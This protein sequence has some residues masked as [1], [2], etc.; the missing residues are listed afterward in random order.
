M[1]KDDLYSS[2]ELKGEW[3]LPNNKEQRI[4]GNLNFNPNIGVR[5]ELSGDFKE[6]NILK[7]RKEDFDIILGI[8]SDNKKITLYRCSETSHSKNFGENRIIELTNYTVLYMFKGIHASCKEELMFNK[9]SARIFNLD[10]WLGIFGLSKYTMPSEENEYTID[11]NYKLP[12]KIKFEIDATTT[13]CFN[14]II[15]YPVMLGSFTKKIHLNQFAKLEFD[16]RKGLDIYE[17]IN[18]LSSFQSFLTFAL[19]ESTAIKSIEVY[20]DQYLDEYEPD[21]YAQVPIEVFYKPFSNGNVELKHRM[22]MLF[23]YKSIQKEFPSIIKKWYSNKELLGSC[24]D[25]VFEQFHNKRFSENT[26]LNLA[27][28]AETFHVRLYNHTKMPKDDYKKMKDEI[29]SATPPL[30]HKWLNEQFNFGNNLNLHNRL[31]ELVDKYS[32]SIIDKMI[33]DKDLFIKQI[34]DSRNYYTHYSKSLEKKALKGNELYYL[35][36]KL[37]ILLVCA[38]LIEIG[39]PKNNLIL[40]LDRVKHTYFHYLAE[41]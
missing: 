9:I 6:A 24:I 38:F 26:F 34:K 25:L 30:Y 21:K 27:Q 33:S 39:I 23:T 18:Y 20:S 19:Y 37:Q 13:G 32:N 1:N 7:G 28:A 16:F 35:T 40:S 12:T 3:F 4:S 15:N 22:F 2:F 10:E 36:K 5:L 17:A 8:T 31:S 11:I 14:F 41:W 29:L